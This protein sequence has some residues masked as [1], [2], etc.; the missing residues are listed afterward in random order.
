MAYPLREDLSS[1][2]GER[3][4]FILGRPEEPEEPDL[5]GSLL[6]LRLGI[7]EG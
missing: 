2:E 4:W 7:M 5:L 6:D 1:L 3:L